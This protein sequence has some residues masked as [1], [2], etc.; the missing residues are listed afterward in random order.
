[1]N[2]AHFHLIINHFPAILMIA[3]AAIGVWAWMARSSDGKRIALGLISAS[4]V[5]ALASYFSGEP[6]SEF[7][8]STA[9][10]N[11]MHIEEHEEAAGLAMILSVA[12]GILSTATL[13]AFKKNTASAKKDSRLVASLG[14]AATI[15]A[16]LALAALVRTGLKGGI[17]R[18]PE[19]NE[20]ISDPLGLPVERSGGHMDESADEHDQETEFQVPSTGGPDQNRD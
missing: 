10:V 17:I 3:A 19:L 5:F 14:F 6:A 15:S 18:H 7:L 20:N 4:S 2:A 16:A 1:M 8:E 11:D 13:F 9:V 12:A